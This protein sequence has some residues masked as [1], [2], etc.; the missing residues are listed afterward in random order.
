MFLYDRKTERRSA[1][2]PPPIKVEDKCFYCNSEIEMSKCSICLKIIC[3]KC[4]QF[5]ICMDCD[6]N[7]LLTRSSKKVESELSIN[8][9]VKKRNC[10]F[11]CSK[12][13]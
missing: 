1:I 4:S 12:S 2:K 8:K 10:F 9:K 5:D 6:E 7:T 11:I 3:P 13:L